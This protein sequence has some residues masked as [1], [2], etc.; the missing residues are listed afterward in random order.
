MIQRKQSLW[1]LLA[2]ICAFL[3]FKLSFYN[4][5]HLPGNAYKELN[6][7]ENFLILILTSGLGVLS[8]INIFLFKTRPTQLRIC[9][10]AILLDALL[11]FLYIKKTN[12]YTQGTYNLW[13]IFHIIIIISLILAITGIRKD[14]KLVKDSERL[15]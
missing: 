3:T 6:G 9:L 14:E 2:S 1:L 10:A 4:G 5:T 7:T 12:E 15:R 8:F 13:S 11:I